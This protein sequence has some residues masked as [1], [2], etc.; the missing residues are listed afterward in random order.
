MNVNDILNKALA[1]LGVNDLTVSAGSADPRLAKLV[2][3]LGVAYMRLITEYAPIER[4]E[5]IA[6]VGGSYD[7]SALSE[8]FFDAV[9]LTDDAGDAASFRLRGKTLI[10][11]DGNYT[12]RYYALPSAYPA[13][14][15]SV[16]VAPQV[17]LDLFARGVAAEYALSSM[18]YEESLL[19]ERKYKE[20]L[21][22]ALTPHAPK[23]ITVKRWI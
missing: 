10:A 6:V 3:A 11:P 12:L 9:R 17:T 5:S 21:M 18:M 19:H 2:T 1:L 13:I 16:E 20:G 23:R 8:G 4:E 15:G 7:L 14:G 22:K